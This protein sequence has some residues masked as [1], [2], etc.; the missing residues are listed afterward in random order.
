MPLLY[1]YSLK[2]DL[3]PF[4]LLIFSQLNHLV[5]KVSLGKKYGISLLRHCN[6]IRKTGKDT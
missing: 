3:D 1:I 5:D 4:K 2:S 6:Q